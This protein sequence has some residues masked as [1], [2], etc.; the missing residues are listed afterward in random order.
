MKK[1]LGYQHPNFLMLPHSC[2]TSTKR[3]PTNLDLVYL[4]VA[5][6][7]NSIHFQLVVFT[8]VTLDAFYF[9]LFYF[10]QNSLIEPLLYYIAFSFYLLQG[11]PLFCLF[12]N[13]AF[14]CPFLLNF[15]LTR[16]HPKYPIEH[17]VHAMSQELKLQL[18]GS[19]G[20]PHLP[21]GL[22]LL[23]RSRLDTL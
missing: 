6:I 4:L 13:S 10:F 8:Q 14:P 15:L 12:Q 9:I 1:P 3:I 20:R 19:V 2:Q 7:R 22:G 16:S 21:H 17:V 5:Y 11:L 23:W 18:H